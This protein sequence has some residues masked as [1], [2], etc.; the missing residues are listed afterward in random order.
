[1]KYHEFKEKKDASRSTLQ[2]KTE[3][4]TKSPD[5]ETILKEILNSA[6]IVSHLERSQKQKKKREEI[7]NLDLAYSA[8]DI[9]PLA[10]DAELIMCD[11]CDVKLDSFEKYHAHKLTHF[12]DDT[13][14][15][16][17]C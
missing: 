5:D 13:T 2:I 14:V 15:C 10:M 9:K 12:S 11:I 7:N 1:M 3:D 6:S 8:I 4:V 17:V 16:P